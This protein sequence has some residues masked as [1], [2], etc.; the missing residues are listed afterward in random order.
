MGMGVSPDGK[1]LATIPSDGPVKLWKIDDFKLIKE[2]GGSGG[3]DTSDVAFSTDGQFVAADLATGLFLWRIS[4]GTDLSG[5]NPGISS[6]AF[7]FSPDGRFL[8]Y[9]D[10]NDN[11]KIILSS[12]DGTKKIKTLEGHQMPVFEVLFSPDGSML[13]SADDQEI[14]IWQVEDGKLLYIEKNECP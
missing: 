4:D 1:M 6:M 14:R 8:A 10:I 5:G 13:A 11:N 9:S 12:Q 7:A 2:L 3:Y